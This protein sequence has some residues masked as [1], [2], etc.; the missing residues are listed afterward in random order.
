MYL[1]TW[2]DHVAPVWTGGDHLSALTISVI[3]FLVV[4]GGSW[5]GAFLGR[6]LPKHHFSSESKDMIKVGIGFLATLAALVLGLLI[7]SAKSSYDTRSE[8]IQ[9]VASKIILLDRN[10]RQYGPAADSAREMMRRMLTAKV[11]LTW[12]KRELAAESSGA[13]A[14]PVIGIEEFQERIR[15]LAPTNDA[16]SVLKTRLVQLSEDMAQTRWLLVEQSGNSIP[17]PFL[18][19]LVLWL[20]AISGCLSLFAPR[21]GTVITV[22]VVCALSFASAVF[23]ILELDTPFEGLLKISDAPLRN[24]LAYVSR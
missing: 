6:I 5:L 13:G 23:L 21:N 1:S 22:N 11:N 2:C 19:V 14:P 7:A 16:Q 8:E 17:M 24:A 3:V 4:L 18:V 15:T 12:V 10:L 20:A 9:Q